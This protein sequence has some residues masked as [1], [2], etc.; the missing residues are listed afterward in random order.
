M[1]NIST[2]TGTF[3][4][5]LNSN[6]DNDEVQKDFWIGFKVVPVIVLTLVTLIGNGLVIV[7]FVRSKQLRKCKNIYIVS[8]AMADFLI[9]CTMPIYILEEIGVPL[10]TL[11]GTLCRVFLMFKYSLFYISLLSIMLISVDRWWSINHPFSYRVRQSRKLA[12]WSVLCCWLLS[13]A[14]YA[15]PTLGWEEVVGNSANDGV[16]APSTTITVT[17]AVTLG[18]IV[19]GAASESSIIADLAFTP[20]RAPFENNL[21]F[22]LLTAIILYLI[23]STLFV[24]HECQHL[25]QNQPAKR[26]ENSTLP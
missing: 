3:M 24:D 26:N 12:F 25:F 14:I 13:F 11:Q 1:E 10:W 8:L 4:N 2:D 16:V 23:P 9:G 15:P 19:P 18:S 20:C 6:E 22:I 21:V 5:K 17:S 7:M